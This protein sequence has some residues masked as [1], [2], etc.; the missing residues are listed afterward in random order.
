MEMWFPHVEKKCGSYTI[1]TLLV[2][3]LYALPLHVAE[4]A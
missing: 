2:K 1:A 4:Y 3:F